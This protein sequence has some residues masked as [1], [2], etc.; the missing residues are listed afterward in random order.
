MNKFVRN[1]VVRKDMSANHAPNAECTLHDF[2][3]DVP[4]TEQFLCPKTNVCGKIFPVCELSQYAVSIFSVF[5]SLFSI[6]NYFCNVN[7]SWACSKSIDEQQ[8]MS[9]RR[10]NH[11]HNNDWI[12]IINYLACHPKMVV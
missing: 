4:V 2:R 11:K 7:T 8:Q 12:A 10:N 5:S 9:S 3:P 6:C 1:K